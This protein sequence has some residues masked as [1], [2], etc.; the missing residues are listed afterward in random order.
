[1]HTVFIQS[2]SAAEEL[3]VQTYVMVGGDGVG[4]VEAKSF[5]KE[6]DLSSSASGITAA[7]SESRISPGVG[8]ANADT[9]SVNGM[10]S[11]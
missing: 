1:M 3:K 7:P 6:L 4:H 10:Y 8:T 9:T 11:I 5:N 2:A